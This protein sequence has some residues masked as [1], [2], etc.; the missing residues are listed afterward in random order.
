VVPLKRKVKKGRRRK[1]PVR[2]SKAKGRSSKKAKADVERI[3]R[4]R[5]REE[6]AKALKRTLA[7]ARKVPYHKK[8]LSKV[9]TI[10]AF[11]DMS[12]VPLL[13]KADLLRS[14]GKR[15]FPRCCHVPAKDLNFIGFTGGPGAEAVDRPLL[16]VPMTQTDM[17]RRSA[18]AARAFRAM[19]EHT[20]RTLVLEEISHSV[21]HQ[22]IVRGMIG[23]GTVPVQ[24]GRGFTLRHVRHTIPR[25]SPRQLVTH[26]TY[27]LSLRDLAE[28]EGL[29]LKLKKV[30][31]WGEI[32]GS[33]KTFRRKVKKAFGAQ[34]FDL[35]AM[36]ELGVL[37]G[38]CTAHDGLHGFEDRFL[39]E[40]IDPE[41][42][43]VLGDGEVGEL[44]VTELSRSA[45]PLIR[46][47]TGD[48]TSL[49]RGRCSCGRTH[50]RLEGIKGK[51][52]QA[53]DDRDGSPVHASDI[54]EILW[55]DPR[56]PGTF[57]IVPGEG[58]VVETKAHKDMTRY[59]LDRGGFP[60]VNVTFERMLPRFYHR[61]EH[62]EDDR[63]HRLL[64]EQMR[65][66]V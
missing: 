48:I 49:T 39:Y 22:A 11:K 65:L 18:M 25:L 63:Y 14:R 28:Q 12:K 52:G 10:A 60:D 62:W 24:L 1:G 40:V 27:A 44:V 35:Y 33:I 30:I 54:A 5:I 29:D 13:S 41:S 58:V 42:G 26:P 31:L 19:G 16:P 20:G 51:V 50:V 37:A 47:R 56:V 34:T 15:R 46:Y 45:M 53:L 3:G 32:G 21:V 6:Q 57:K 2:G 38:E 9:P 64:K 55:G 61:T 4:R 23:L 7:W 43:E 59:Y 17:I 66:E 8:R 36:Q